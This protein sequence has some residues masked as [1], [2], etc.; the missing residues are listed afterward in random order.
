[1]LL[2]ECQEGRVHAA[3]EENKLAPKQSR[4]KTRNLR[5]F[6]FVY[7]TT[8]LNGYLYLIKWWL[9]NRLYHHF[10]IGGA[11][12][13][14]P[15][16]ILWVKGLQ[17]WFGIVVLNC[18]FPLYIGPPATHPAVQVTAASLIPMHRVV[19]Q[20]PCTAGGWGATVQGKTVKLNQC[21]SPFILRV[22]EG[23]RGWTHQL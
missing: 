14:V 11:R 23:L 6:L 16:M 2:L 19:L 10:M 20:F 5:F 21:C 9:T 12:P 17:H 7:Q 13:L 3:Q 4:L 8:P 1:M 18:F 15:P 22:S